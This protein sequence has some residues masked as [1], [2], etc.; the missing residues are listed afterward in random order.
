MGQRDDNKYW[1]NVKTANP[2]GKLG[3]AGVIRQFDTK[4]EAKAYAN[5]VNE[6]GE[7]CFIKTKEEVPEAPVR[8]QGDVFESSK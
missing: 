3:D 7:D 5:C 2:S 6:T 4:E 8:H 1:V